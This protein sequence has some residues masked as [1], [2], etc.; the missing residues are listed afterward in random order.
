MNKSSRDIDKK[1]G[2]KPLPEVFPAKRGRPA[3]SGRKVRDD[4]SKPVLSTYLSQFQHVHTAHLPLAQEHSCLGA[5]VEA[6][7]SAAQADA[8]NQVPHGRAR[9]VTRAS[10]ASK[11]GCKPGRK[12][13]KKAKSSHKHLRQFLQSV[14]VNG[15]TFHVGDSAY[16][17]MTIDFNEDEFAEEEVCQVCGSAEQEDVP[18][19][20]CNKCL[21][22]YHL[23]CL[24]PPLA[25]VPKVSGRPVFLHEHPGHADTCHSALF[26]DGGAY[27]YEVNICVSNLYAGKSQHCS[28]VCTDD[29]MGLWVEVKTCC[30]QHPQQQN[31]LQ[32]K[33]DFSFIELRPRTTSTTRAQA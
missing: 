15:D 14:M 24:K 3:G 10:K 28:A 33:I 5:Q 30:G 9:A 27:A 11:A 1:K 13:C 25:E 8:S 16:L 18:I 29:E 12:R 26:Y 7:P 21:L 22:G 17:M 20:E 23:N 31:G 4:T 19:L 2:S 32:V 6:A